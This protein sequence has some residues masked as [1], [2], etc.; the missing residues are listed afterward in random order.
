MIIIT[1]AI[2]AFVATCS[3]VVY[4]STESYKIKS[5]IEYTVQPGDTISSLTERYR[6]KDEKASTFSIK[7]QLLN[8]NNKDIKPGDRVLI[9]V[10][11]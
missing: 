1:A 2:I 11:E 3:S 5:T 8:E 10:E 7:L 6:P 4:S 9:P